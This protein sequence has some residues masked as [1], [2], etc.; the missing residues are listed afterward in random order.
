MPRLIWTATRG[1]MEILGLEKHQSET[2]YLEGKFRVNFE[3]QQSGNVLLLCCRSVAAFFDPNPLSGNKQATCCR[4]AIPYIQWRHR[5]RCQANP[6]N[7]A[8]FRTRTRLLY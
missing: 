5:L 7:R 4:F 6:T 2:Q 8:R 3:W 1:V